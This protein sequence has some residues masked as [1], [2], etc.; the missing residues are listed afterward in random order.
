MTSCGGTCTRMLGGA[1]IRLSK[2]LL[3][4]RP[5]KDTKDVLL[6]EM[7]H[8]HMMVHGIRDNDPGGHG[9]IFKRKMREINDS[10][11]PDMHRP[12]GGYHIS[13]FHTMFAEVAYY[14]QHHWK[15][16]RCGDVVKRSINRKPQKADCRWR[17]GE[18]NC[19]DVTCR[20]HLHTSYCGGEYVKIKEPEGYLK[21]QK[22]KENMGGDGGNTSKHS[23]GT[24]GILKFVSK[25][26]PDVAGREEEEEV[27]DL[28]MNDTR[29]Q[30]IV[31]L[32]ES[33]MNVNKMKGLSCP[34]CGLP[35]GDGEFGLQ[36]L[37]EHLDVHVAP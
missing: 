9:D 20:W 10:R 16:E 5:L 3:S 23:D 7:I 6:H 14:R 31:D 33:V 29:T 17:T 21:K 25:M 11:V 37:N 22:K 4:L 19:K 34:L 24:E 1:V 2:P 27:V 35:C 8:A 28:T 36:F 13:V 12:E 15:C 26:V 30:D 32:T 18:Q